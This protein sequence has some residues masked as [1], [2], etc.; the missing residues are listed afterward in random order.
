[1]Q[2]YMAEDERDIRRCWPVM[3]QLRPHLDEQSFADQVQRQ[4]AQGYRL[5]YVEDDG[6]VVAV[7]GFR[8]MEMLSRGRHIYVDDL[9]TDEAGRSNG[10]GAA[11][12][13]WLV[14]YARG[15]DLVGVELDSG[16]QRFGAHR[17]YFRQGMHIASYHF[18][19]TGRRFDGRG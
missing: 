6:A 16:V 3:V 8:E 1:M 18:T 5:A 9:V 15:R 4:A 12:M 11:L 13:D 2:I 14:Q 10:Y 19:L 7:A 17:F